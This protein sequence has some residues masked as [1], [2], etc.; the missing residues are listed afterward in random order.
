[1][2]PILIFSTLIYII[3]VYSNNQRTWLDIFFK[4]LKKYVL[5]IIIWHLVSKYIKFR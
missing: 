4:Y 1:M 2:I 3:L 5:S